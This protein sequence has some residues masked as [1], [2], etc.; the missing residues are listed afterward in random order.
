ML[1]RKKYY[2]SKARWLPRT[3]A[4]HIKYT[5]HL[6]DEG[7]DK[8]EYNSHITSSR[9]YYDN[10]QLQYEVHLTPNRKY[11]HS[12]ENL[13]GLCR[14]YHRNGLLFHTEDFGEGSTVR[15]YDILEKM[16]SFDIIGY[17]S[18]AAGD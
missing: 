2:P 12:G 8:L 14:F 4:Q 11:P 7:E 10:G 1:E 13:K 6:D 17:F 16:E 5:I 9:H 18:N 15:K 3:L